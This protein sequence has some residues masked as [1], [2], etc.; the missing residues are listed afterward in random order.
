MGLQYIITFSYLSSKQLVYFSYKKF[1]YQFEGIKREEHYLLE[2]KQ[3]RFDK[4]VSIRTEDSNVG[5]DDNGLGMP[6]DDRVGG[7][8]G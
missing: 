8:L 2:K 5:N 7:G 6:Y 4:K 3:N 1:M